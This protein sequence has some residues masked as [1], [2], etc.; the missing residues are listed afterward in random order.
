MSGQKL[1][2]LRSFDLKQGAVAAGDDIRRSGLLLHSSHLTET[3]TRA[4]S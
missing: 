4:E 2:E 1:K 3:L